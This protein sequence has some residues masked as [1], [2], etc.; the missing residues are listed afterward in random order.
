MLD[1]EDTWPEPNYNPGPAK[2]LHALGVVSVTYN[3]FEEGLVSLYRHHLLKA[4]LPIELIDLYYFQLDE[5]RRLRAIKSIFKKDEKNPEVI[6]AVEN[7][8]D[9]F[10]WCWDARNKLLHAEPYPS[11]FSGTSGRLHLTKRV[12]KKDHTIGY[13][14]PD[15]PT[16]RDIANKIEAGKRAC[17]AI[18]VYLRYHLVP[19]ENASPLLRSMMPLTLPQKLEPPPT[20]ELEPRPYNDPMPRHPPQPSG[21]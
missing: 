15:L 2:H 9:Y 19:L 10:N 8:L 13:I 5:G 18:I 14:S 16:L 1:S 20:L 17:A 6:K 12:S 21:A 3:A 7:V 4:N 11:T